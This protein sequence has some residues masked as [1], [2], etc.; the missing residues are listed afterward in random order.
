MAKLSMVEK[1]AVVEDAAHYNFGKD[2]VEDNHI[3]ADLTDKE[4]LDI[5]KAR[6]NQVIVDE[7]NTYKSNAA[8]DIARDT[9]AESEHTV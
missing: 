4:K 9:E 1:N 3:F 2:N 6:Q 7:A 8:Q 5:V